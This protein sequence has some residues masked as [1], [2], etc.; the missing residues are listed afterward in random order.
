MTRC[1]TFNMEVN[2]NIERV[3][4]GL[5]ARASVTGSYEHILWETARKHKLQRIFNAGQTTLE[6]FGYNIYYKGS[7]SPIEEFEPSK[8]YQLR[9]KNSRGRFNMEQHTELDVDVQD[10]PQNTTKS[11][12][13]KEINTG[14]RQEFYEPNEDGEY[15]YGHK[16]DEMVEIVT[17]VEHEGVEVE[18]SD[19]YRY[20][21][22]P[23]PRSS[24]GRFLNR[25]GTLEVGQDVDVQFDSDGFG[26]VVIPRN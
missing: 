24:L 13:V 21:S 1:L 20:Y 7:A 5:E 17:E 18:S 19:I 12:K 25:Y 26:E 15:E 8:S 14:E 22:D 4:E 11:G 6:Q 16:K 2:E 23:H 9:F 10:R 3:A